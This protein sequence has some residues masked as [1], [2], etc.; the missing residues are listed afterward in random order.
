MSMCVST[1]WPE[2]RGQISKCVLRYR[3][4][5]SCERTYLEVSGTEEVIA[6]DYGIPIITQ[7]KNTNNNQSA[8]KE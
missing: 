1:N 7:S 4:L 6:F 5:S 3:C 2:L 8:K